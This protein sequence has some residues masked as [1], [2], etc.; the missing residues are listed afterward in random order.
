MLSDNAKCY[1]SK[2]FTELCDSKGI[3]QSF[4]RTYTPQTNGKAERFVQTMKRRWAYEHVFRTSALR[5][6]S[7]HPWVKHYNHE[8]PHREIGK[9]PPMARLRATRQQAA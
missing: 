5:A 1:G 9:K 4:T 6:A 2:A 3:D 8:R 7:L